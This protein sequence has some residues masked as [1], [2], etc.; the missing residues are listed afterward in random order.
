MATCGQIQC[1]EKRAFRKTPECALYMG[2]F[3][4]KQMYKLGMQ[5]HAD[6]LRDCSTKAVGL[7]KVMTEM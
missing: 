4:D 5:L 3:V 6:N 2:P 1:V 7:V